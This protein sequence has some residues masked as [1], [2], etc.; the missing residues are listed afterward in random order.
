VGVILLASC[1]AFLY[2]VASA[3]G[4]LVMHVLEQEWIFN[5]ARK[6]NKLQPYLCKALDLSVDM[7]A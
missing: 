4:R 1:V 2:I 7:G 3:I 5:Y 6:V